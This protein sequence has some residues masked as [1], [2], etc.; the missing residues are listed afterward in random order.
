MFH[1][2]SAPDVSQLPTGAYLVR[3]KLGSIEGYLVYDD[4]DTQVYRFK[5]H[6]T[7][8]GKRWSMV[9]GAGTDL[10]SMVRPPLHVHP[11]FTLSRP[12]RADVVIRKSNFSPIRESWR[13]EGAKMA[14]ST[15]GATFSIMN[16]PSRRTDRP[17]EQRPG[18]GSPS[19]TPTQSR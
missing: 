2:Q 15:S 3:R 5:G 6:L 9:D 19:L 7:F 4:T 18:G 13:V 12:G 8:P 1:H 10:A 16:S 11:M 17:G 14:T